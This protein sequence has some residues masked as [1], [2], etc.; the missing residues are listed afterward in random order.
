MNL[1]DNRLVGL[2]AVMLFGMSDVLFSVAAIGQT[3]SH[4]SAIAVEKPFKA[5]ASDKDKKPRG[6]SGMDCLGK[7]GDQSRE[8]LVVND[9]ETFVEVA[10]LTGKTMRPTGTTIAIVEKGEAGVGILGTPR[11]AKCGEKGKFAELDGEGISVFGDYVYVIS[12]HSCSSAGKYKPSSYLISRFKMASS[13]AFVSGA[14]PAAVERTWRGGD[15][16]VSSGA[17]AAYGLPKKEGTN[18]EG[19]AVVGDHLYAGLRTPTSGGSAYLVRAP[20]TAL[21]APGK[22]P[23]AANTVETRTLD[24]GNNTGVRDFASMIDGSLLILTGPTIEQAGVEYQ[25]WHLPAPVWTSKPVARVV[26]KTDAKAKK[27]SE[28]AKAEVITVVRQVGP[29]VNV[30]VGYDNVDDGAPTEHEIVLGP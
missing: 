11:I 28:V 17:A 5:P 1:Y 24:F 18:I 20:V 21:F 19:I 22:D 14:A 10:V 23:L 12:S 8:C 4:G 2:L 9:E 26:V 13:T 27:P 29:K 15:M 30:I 16:L 7:D 25:V 6:L 3:V